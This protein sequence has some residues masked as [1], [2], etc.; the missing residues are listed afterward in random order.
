MNV[1]IVG[2]G[3]AGA[4]AAQ[5]LREHDAQ[6]DIVLLGEERWAPYER[7]PLSK[8]A[9]KDCDQAPQFILTQERA[10]AQGIRLITT[11][12]VTG[13][14]R[15]HKRVE[16][17][18]HGVFHY[19][20]LVLATGGRARRLQIRGHDLPGVHY[21][22]TWEDALRMR[23]AMRVAR[24][25]LV[26]GG[27]WIGLEVAATARTQGCEVT[28]VEAG[29]RLCARSV[30]PR[31]S[32]FLARLHAAHGVNVKLDCQVEGI[33]ADPAGEVTVRTS[34][35]IET[36]DLVIVGI[37]LEPRTELAAGCGLDVTNGI[38]VDTWGRTSDPNIYA[39]GDVANQPLDGMGTHIR[40][41]TYANAIHHA[42]G[43]ADHIAG[44]PGLGT[45]IPW[46]W[47][48]QF[49][50]KL[51]V[52]GLPSEGGQWVSRGDEASGA[53]CLFQIKDDKLR[54]TVSVNM[55]KEIKLAKRWMKAG[56]LPAPQLL[57]D[58]SV[59]LDKL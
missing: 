11:T 53:F 30:T 41:E 19:D 38:V 17:V 14:D 21:L 34:E 36:A 48:D 56:T 25:L 58:L 23:D 26:I 24:S 42:Q 32:E 33:E 39:T 1:V 13:I 55:V 37:G 45:D 44:K 3:Q 27:G 22:R 35:G 6:C 29:P 57:S 49:E 16:T 50:V 47:S 20:K 28:V 31:I 5:R 40:F 52:L 12:R 9:L 18:G 7:P 59:R 46:F 10:Q 43:V 2:A 54:A 51:Q 4:W 15:E 8:G